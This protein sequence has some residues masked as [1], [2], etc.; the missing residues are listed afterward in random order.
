MKIHTGD[1]V[2]I[3]AGKDKGKTGKVTQAFPTT[4]RIVVEGVNR[5]K[6]HMPKRGTTP[7]QIVELD[8]SIHVSNAAFLDAATKK[9]TR[10]GF[11]SVD[12]KKVRISKATKKPV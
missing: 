5:V 9:P 11:A 6:R 2:R 10:L 8:K 12:G 1:T 3:I 7:G 4:N